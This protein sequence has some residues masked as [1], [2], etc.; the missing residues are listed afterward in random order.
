LTHKNLENPEALVTEEL[1]SSVGLCFMGCVSLCPVTNKQ[2]QQFLQENDGST[3]RV[4]L[5][6]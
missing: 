2:F 4:Q 6:I 3:A 1:K 5:A